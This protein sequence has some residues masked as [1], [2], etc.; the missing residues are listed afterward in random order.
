MQETNRIYRFVCILIICFTSISPAEIFVNL[1]GYRINDPKI[2]LV[3]QAADSFE[4]HDATNNAIVFKDQLELLS[5]NDPATGMD[6]YWG[7][8]SELIN[9]GHYY[10]KI[11]N[12]DSSFHFI[13]HDSIYFPLFKKSLKGLYFQRCGF[14]LLGPT[15]GNYYHSRCH[16]SDGIFHST[17]DSSGFHLAHGGWHDAGDYGKYIVNAGISVGTLLMAYEYFPLLFSQD[18]LNIAESGNDVPDILDETRFELEWMLTMQAPDGG[19]YHKLTREQFAP[20][21]MPQND[22]GTRY[23]YQISSTATGDFASVMARAA[24]IYQPLDSV[25]SNLCLNAAELAWDY[26]TI[27][28]NIVPNGGFSNPSG[29]ATGVYG[30]SDDRDER[31]WAAAELYLTTGD[32]EY[33]NYFI[34]NYNAAGLI[35]SAMSWRNVK[36]MA[37]LA[38]I[39]GERH[40]INT[41]IQN[42][43]TTSLNSFCQN[44]VIRSY[45]NGFYVTLNPGE[46]WW[47]CNS[48]VMN[49]AILLILGYEKLQ[50]DSFKNVALDQ[51]NYILG[52]NAHGFSF[53]TGIGT[54][55]PMFPHHRPSAADGIPEPIPG[56]LVG[57]PDQY[58]SDPVLQAHFTSSTPPALCYLDDQNS[59]ASNEI[60]I[61]WN[62]PLIFV[63]GYFAGSTLSNIYKSTKGQLIPSHFKLQQN[64]P[65]PFNSRTSIEFILMKRMK[66]QL[67]LFDVRGSFV[68]ELLNE[69][70]GPGNHC[71]FLD[72]ESLSSGIYWYKL[73]AESGSQSKKMVLIK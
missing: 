53:V 2:V 40:D 16:T 55:S 27:H 9:A 43:L 24:R 26:L 17:T 44:L 5:L 58:L 56:L 15:A 50:N 10:C 33:H 67:E 69:D 70:L 63:S 62:A 32:S 14:D 30:D 31:I 19:V 11:T 35:N 34:S 28:P 23:I 46:Y 57:G 64:Y 54:V 21:V 45:S 4:I 65:N 12:N 59:Y 60:A 71:I 36:P 41:S 3:N 42:T 48:T 39:F 47:G 8:F 1:L 13:V 25:F 20:F 49:N 18:N 73:S 6:L 72:A 61:N 68:R 37:H 51:I 66:V 7:D 38:Y 22:T 52:L 29:T